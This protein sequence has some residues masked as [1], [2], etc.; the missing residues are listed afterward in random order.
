[1]TREEEQFFRDVYVR[2]YSELLQYC[3]IKLNGNQSQAQEIC[4]DTF[5]VF[6]DEPR[7]FPNEKAIRAFL[8]RTTRNLVARF[9]L[10]NKKERERLTS[11]DSMPPGV[12]YEKLSY[13]MDF[14]YW[15]GL[16]TPIAEMKQEILEA[17]TKEEQELYTWYFIEHL[18]PDSIGKRLGISANAVHQRL[19]RLRK[20]I[21]QQVK[22]LKLV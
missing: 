3:F 11:L 18:S 19:H 22:Q 21:K 8:F 1:M 14:E 15:L 17:L 6:M 9:Y 12:E 7:E 2:F 10:K 20:N 16:K 4:Q 5:L 13:Q